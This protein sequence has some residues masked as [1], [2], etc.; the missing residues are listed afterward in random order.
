MIINKKITL[1]LLIAPILLNNLLSFNKKISLIAIATV[2]ISIWF[3]YGNEKFEKVNFINEKLNL[4]KL[5]TFF[6]FVT[7]L[8]TQ[9]I[10]LQ[11]ETLDWDVHSYL[12]MALDIDRGFLPLENQWESK[13]PVLYYLYNFIFKLSQSNFVF[14]KIANDL[15]LFVVSIFI[16][17][18]CKLITNNNLLISFSSA[19]FFI[20]LMSQPWAMSEYSELYSLIFL[21][22]SSFITIKNQLNRFNLLVVFTSLSI[23]TLINQ[24]T[25]LFV[26]SFIFYYF[27]ILDFQLIR[28]NLIYIL[29]GLALPHVFFLGLY[30]FNNLIG[31]YIGTFIDIPLGYTGASLSSARELIV[32]LRS[33]FNQ[34]IHLFTG[35]I[36]LITVILLDSISKKFKNLLNPY[37]FF[38]VLN[39]FT[40]LL[41]Y[42]IG[43]HN[44]YHHLFFLIF[45]FSFLPTAINSNEVKIGFFILIFL[46]SVVLNLKNFNTS[47]NNIVNL[48]SHL[49]NYPIYQ[50]SKMIQENFDD[51][52]TVLALDYVAVLHYLNK[53][54][55]SYIIHPS[56]HFEPYI[57]TTLIKNN[58]IREDEVN[59][60]ILEGPDVILCSGRRIEMGQVVQNKFY[61]C[62][63]SDWNKK[64]IQIESLIYQ[65][66]QYL[67]F[68]N[69]PYRDVSIYFKMP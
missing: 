46:S 36:F 45:F 41:F 58:K 33:F 20:L 52:F 43:S 18:S 23:S 48:D 13:G 39:I 5:L 25:I 56:N 40:S 50:A 19:L 30:F 34:D 21:G 6:L 62:A 24:G 4:S 55:F 69:D 14:F 1:L 51:E 31:I 22:L 60:L 53:S 29:S 49:E 11:Y 66:N 54:N 63:I 8:I 59:K 3:F 65:N 9:N 44:Y 17:K 2:L 68:Y 35:I 42:F 32:F 61:N 10:G 67:N 28:K 47:F 37:N 7:C 27:Y 15:L 64:Y 38:I 16:F 57:S 12:V 26:F